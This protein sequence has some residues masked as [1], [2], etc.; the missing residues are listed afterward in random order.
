[1]RLMIQESAHWLRRSRACQEICFTVFHG[2]D[3]EQWNTAMDVVLGRTVF[4][5]P[6][7]HEVGRHRQSILTW[8]SRARGRDVGLIRPLQDALKNADSLEPVP[9][10]NAARQAGEA[11][12]LE[13][14]KHFNLAPKSS[15][16]PMIESLHRHA[17]PMII[18]HL[19]VLRALGNAYSHFSEDAPTTQAATARF[20]AEAL[21]SVSVL[22]QLRP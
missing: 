2:D 22:L 9:I 19:H 6:E 14:L 17:P 8:C 16:Q 13:W 5:P 21:R 11:M 15:L 4:H 7:D 10:C 18:A 20:I 12:G 3:V 1:M